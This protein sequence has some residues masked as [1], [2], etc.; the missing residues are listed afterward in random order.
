MIPCLAS[1]SASAISRGR[2]AP[3]TRRYRTS[4]RRLALLRGH[5][6]TKGLVGHGVVNAVVIEGLCS[7]KRLRPKLLLADDL[8]RSIGPSRAERTCAANR[9][10]NGHQLGTDRSRWENSLA[11][12]D[13][14]SGDRRLRRPDC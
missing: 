5:G 3:G 11:R 4:R 8:L 12:F 1:S 14:N 6:R 13:S 2:S 7:A 9:L 10:S